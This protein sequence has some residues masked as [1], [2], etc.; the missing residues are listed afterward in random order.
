MLLNR[1]HVRVLVPVGMHVIILSNFCC[2]D[3]SVCFVEVKVQKLDLE[4]CCKEVLCLILL[5]GLWVIAGMNDL[6]VMVPAPIDVVTAEAIE[7]NGGPVVIA[8]QTEGGTR[9]G[10]AVGDPDIA[11]TLAAKA[12]TAAL[13]KARR[14]DRSTESW[15]PQ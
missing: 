5:S 14:E 8:S 9:V 6:D 12:A 7:G 15:R 11:Q 13:R 1:L 3:V 4:F 2:G 10:G